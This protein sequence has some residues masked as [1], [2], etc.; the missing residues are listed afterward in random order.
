MS[1]IE[2]EFQLNIKPITIFESLLK[3]KN[4][5]IE[6]QND[7]TV[8]YSSSEDINITSKIKNLLIQSETDKNID[9]DSI[10][11]PKIENVDESNNANIED[12]QDNLFSRR[13]GLFKN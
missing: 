7:V 10:L 4:S 9:F 12:N 2:E 11:N 5:T 1:I 13:N 3:Q 8:T 6:L